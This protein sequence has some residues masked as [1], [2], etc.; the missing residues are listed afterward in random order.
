MI[1]MLALD[2]QTFCPRESVFTQAGSSAHMD[3]VAT[4]WWFGRREYSGS[5]CWLK[6]QNTQQFEVQI[7]LRV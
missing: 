5:E 3:T 2:S 1:N 7:Y 4:V 6:M